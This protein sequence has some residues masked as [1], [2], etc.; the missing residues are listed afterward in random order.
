MDVGSDEAERYFSSAGVI[1]SPKRSRLTSDHLNQ[2]SFL[3]FD[4][5]ITNNYTQNKDIKRSRK[6]W[7]EEEGSDEIEN[8]EN[9][10]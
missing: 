10:Q 5:R 3:K 2:L 6:M 8:L 1:L 4:D 7:E 9:L